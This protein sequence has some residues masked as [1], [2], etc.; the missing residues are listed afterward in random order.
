M[1]KIT[2]LTF[3]LIINT[4]ILAASTNDY[5]FISPMP[6]SDFNTRESNIIIREGS[7]LNPS[8]I[9]NSGAI[10]ISGSESGRIDGEIILSSDKKTL[11]FK[12]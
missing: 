12:P 9:Y 4:L 11:I 1:K 5:Q 8:S 6:G 3:T 10:Q 2:V 7:L